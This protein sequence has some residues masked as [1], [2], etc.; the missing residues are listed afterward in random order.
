M[1]VLH[2]ATAGSDS[3]DGSPDRPLRTIDRAAQLAQPGDSVVVH[4]GVYREWVR[5]RCGGLSDRRRITYE[6]AP[7][8]HVLI[9]GSE[10]VTGWAPV[11]GSVWTVSVPNELFGSF[12]PFAEEID[13]DWIVHPEKDSPRKHLGDVY[14]NGRSFYE[15]SSAAELSDPPLRTEV[16][17]DW[18]GL[19]DRVRDPEQTRFVWYAEVDEDT[20]TIRA[21]FQG[22][23]PNAE[24][25]ETAWSQRAR[26]AVGCPTGSRGPVR[27]R[28]IPQ[29]DPQRVH[30]ARGFRAAPPAGILNPTSATCLREPARHAD[31]DVPDLPRPVLRRGRR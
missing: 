17:D 7:G 5:P 14:L 1:P 13:G 24:L 15:V 19:P 29:R 4:E 26:R 21:N 6:A 16:L 20:T 22:A 10:Q 11:E 31:R 9:T 27:E 8:E 2:V 25:V 18:T 28:A 12:N 30:P 23:D 3:S